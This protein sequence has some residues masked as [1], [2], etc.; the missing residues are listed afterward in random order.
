L[1]LSQYYFLFFDSSYSKQ[2]IANVC[3]KIPESEKFSDLMRE[4]TIRDFFQG[5]KD[6]WW[7][8]IFPMLLVTKER[9][10][11]FLCTNS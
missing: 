8:I 1:D 9:V 6:H 10:A 5:R 2:E 4:V 11:P 7:N 3:E